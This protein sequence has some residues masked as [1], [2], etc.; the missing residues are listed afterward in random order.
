MSKGAQATKDVPMSRDELRNLFE[1][2]ARAGD[3][4]FAVAWALMDLADAQGHTAGAIQ[5]LGNGN[6][7]THF[8][9][10]ENLAMQV[11]KIAD[12]VGSLDLA[13]SGEKIT[14]ALSEL[15]LKK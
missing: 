14:D 10:I 5:R 15:E 11:E 4:A 7:S 12:A 1:K 13:A 9:A 2:E 3:G 6:A 8:G